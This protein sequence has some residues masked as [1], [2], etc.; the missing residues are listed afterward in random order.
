[1]AAGVFIDESPSGRPTTARKCCSYCEVKQD[2]IEWCPL[3]WGLGATSFSKI[4]FGERTKREESHVKKFTKI[5]IRRGT[6]CTSNCYITW[7]SAVKNSSTAKTP[8]PSNELTALHATSVAS[9]MIFHGTLAGALTTWQ[10]F[11]LHL[12]IDTQKKKMIK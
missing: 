5:E 12:Q 11:S 8:A 9:F 10:M 7:P 1:M 4:W 3:L 2:S 6:K